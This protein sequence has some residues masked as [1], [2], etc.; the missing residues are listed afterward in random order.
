MFFYRRWMAVVAVVASVVSFSVADFYAVAVGYSCTITGTSSSEILNGTAGNDVI[1]TNGGSDLV[2]A[3]DGNDIIVVTGGGNVQINAGSG[4]DVIDAALGSSV[5]VNAGSGDDT[6][7]GT[8]GADTIDAGSGTD[9]ITAGLGDDSVTGAAGEILTDDLGDGNDTFT[10]GSASSV[11]VE[12]GLGNDTI[13]GTANND[14]LNGGG[15]NDTIT[16]LAGNDSVDA[17]AGDDVVEQCLAECIGRTTQATLDGDI[18]CALFLRLFQGH[19]VD[20]VDRPLR[21]VHVPCG[22]NARRWTVHGHGR[23]VYNPFLNGIGTL[24]RVKPRLP[25]CDC[26]ANDAVQTVEGFAG[27]NKGQG[28][29]CKIEPLEDHAVAVQIGLAFKGADQRMRA[30]TC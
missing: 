21:Q 11:S 25:A 26:A 5:T 4:N 16:G 9:I 12:G 19:G 7:T 3:G 27:I 6:I 17:G 24:D 8:P 15:G 18:E 30:K 22:N 13:T 20:G 14:T 10:G 2:V 29:L 28:Q 1:C 23:D